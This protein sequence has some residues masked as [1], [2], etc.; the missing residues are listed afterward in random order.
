MSI[1]TIVLL[2][3]ENDAPVLVDILNSHSRGLTVIPVATL[4]DLRTAFA[5]LP[6]Q[7]RLLSFCSPVIVPPDLL[8]ALHS[9]AYNFHPG[10]PERPGRYPA[11][12]ALYDRAERFGITVHEMA[13]PVDSGPIVTAEWF[14]MPEGADL[15]KLEALT[16]E[17][18]LTV[19]R[20]LAPYMVNVARPLPRL[21]YRWSGRKTRK[22]QCDDLCQITPGMEATE[23]ARRTLACGG[24]LKHS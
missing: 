13:G 22:S 14:F 24:F 23:I 19:F 4:D 7:T 8:A 21:L 6:A 15:M 20:R 10:P 9:P 18:L 11:V 12:F 16:Y 2:T 17:R 3:S 5:Q 1:S